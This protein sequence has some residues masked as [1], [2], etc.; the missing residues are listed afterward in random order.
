MYL[1]NVEVAN[2]IF[3]MTWESS[4]ASLIAIF[5]ISANVP[6]YEVH[7]QLMAIIP[8]TV[9]ENGELTVS[10]NWYNVGMVNHG[11]VTDYN[12]S[13]SDFLNYVDEN[14]TLQVVYR[15]QQ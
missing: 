13:I 4:R 10:S 1:L 3:E 7:S 9:L 12:N 2:T 8:R 6:D 15:K 5:D 14:H 11:V